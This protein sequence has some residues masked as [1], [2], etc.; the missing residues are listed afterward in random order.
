MLVVLT[1]RTERSARMALGKII[2][3]GGGR[4]GGRG[5]LIGID[6]SI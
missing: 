3:A 6:E 2:L 1:S 5:R 4:L